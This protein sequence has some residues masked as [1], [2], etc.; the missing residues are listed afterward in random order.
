[1]FMPAPAEWFHVVHRGVGRRPVFARTVDVRKFLE[2]VAL[3][4]DRGA[5][6]LHAYAVLTN[7][8]HLLVR[9]RPSSLWDG[10]RGVFAPY[11]RRINQRLRRDGPLFGSRPRRRRIRSGAHWRATIAYIDR[12]PVDAGLASRA[13]QYPFGSAWHYARSSGPAWLQRG[14]I[15]EF[16]RGEAG[17]SVY[18]PADYAR[19]FGDAELPGGSQVVVARR[20]ARPERPDDPLDGLLAAAPA[21]VRRWL[22]RL[23]LRADGA[24]AGPSLVDPSTLLAELEKAKHTSGAWTLEAGLAS[25]VA[26]G[27]RRKRR[28]G[29]RRDGWS[30]LACGLLRTASGLTLDEI[31]QL[32]G[33]SVG[34]VHFQIRC[35]SRLVVLDGPYKE[36]AARLLSATLKK[37]FPESGTACC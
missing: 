8:C 1:M 30:V 28:G 35:H 25:E 14:V 17:A 2:L 29:L 10:L 19:V 16:V 3:H 18:R 36:R 21:D 11:A 5:F 24:S 33:L 34:G 32:V 31:G 6:E 15:E 23:A 7:H 20:L 13:A 26:G 4:V 22:E 27:F 37:D 12:N 9:G